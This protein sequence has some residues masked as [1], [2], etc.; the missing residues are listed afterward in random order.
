MSL[1][2]SMYVFDHEINRS[3]LSG[4]LES[5]VRVA[6]SSIPS[7][8]YYQVVAKNKCEFIAKKYR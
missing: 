7:Y 6:T 2:G 4:L 5:C 1:F 8:T 3:R